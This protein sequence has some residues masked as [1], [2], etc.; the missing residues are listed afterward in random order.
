MLAPISK[1]VLFFTAVVDAKVCFMPPQHDSP[2]DRII[3]AAAKQT[4]L[5]PAQIKEMEPVLQAC[6]KHE[7]Y[8]TWTKAHPPAESDLTGEPAKKMYQV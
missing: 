2:Q 1:I 5:T 8:N 4:G 6:M 7:N 3:E